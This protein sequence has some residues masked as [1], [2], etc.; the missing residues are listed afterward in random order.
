MFQ[1]MGRR[2]LLPVS[3]RPSLT[4]QLRITAAAQAEGTVMG[5]VSA[6]A[7]TAA[8]LVEVLAAV[9]TTE[10]SRDGFIF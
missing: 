9:D 8:I 2:T 1:P 3:S 6:V 7:G 10:I 4:P 5:V